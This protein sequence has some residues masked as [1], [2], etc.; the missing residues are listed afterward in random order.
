MDH[1]IVAHFTNHRPARLALEALRRDPRRDRIEVS[2]RVPGKPERRIPLS[3]RRG[4]TAL[5]G[6]LI[7]AVTGLLVGATIGWA[8]VHIQDLHLSKSIVFAFAALGLVLGCVGAALIGPFNLQSAL[9]HLPPQSGVTLV[10]NAHRE[11]DRLWI[12]DVL[13]GH[14]GIIEGTAA[15]P[16]PLPPEP[17]PA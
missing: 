1:L 9:E 7:G 4:E 14:D 8:A 11:A 15:G 13:R 10:F 5:R 16:P 12:E 2:I 6:V 3:L 17:H